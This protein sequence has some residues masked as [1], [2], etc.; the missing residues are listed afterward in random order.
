MT[1]TAPVTWTV[2]SWMHAASPQIAWKSVWSAVASASRHREA[3]TGV[4]PGVS[5]GDNWTL[6]GRMEGNGC[7]CH[8]EFRNRHRG[9]VCVCVC[10]NDC[11]HVFVTCVCVCVCALV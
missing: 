5:A 4:D 7:C 11:L 10:V 8:F 1:A 9:N 3:C 6:D 2:A